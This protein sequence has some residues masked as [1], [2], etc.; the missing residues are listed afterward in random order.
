[1]RRSRMMRRVE[2]EFCLKRERGSLSELEDKLLAAT[3]HSGAWYS[4]TVRIGMAMGA[5]IAYQ[6]VLGMQFVPQ[7]KETQ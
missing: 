6:N 1:M 5:I 3:P 4:A 7:E 2:I